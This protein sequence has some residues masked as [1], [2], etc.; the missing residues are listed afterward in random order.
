VL[1]GLSL[2]EL[3]VAILQAYIF[4]MLTVVF[5]GGAVNPQH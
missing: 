4:T 3:F 5:V 1:L 2:L